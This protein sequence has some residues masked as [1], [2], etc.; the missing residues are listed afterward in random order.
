MG[1]NLGS[2][3]GNMNATSNNGVNALNL[4]K[5]DVFARKYFY[6]ITA[7][8][9][10]FKNKYRSVELKNARKLAE[11]VLVIPL[12]G[13]LNQNNVY[14]IYKLIKGDSSE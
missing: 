10:C 7:D 12:Y 5:N 8:A 1:I 14:K 13:E 2:M 3:M 6:P 11:E 4:K 9:A